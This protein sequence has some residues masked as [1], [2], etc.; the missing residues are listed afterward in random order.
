MK[1]AHTHASS[2]WAW[3]PVQRSPQHG[4]HSDHHSQ[5][6]G[7]PRPKQRIGMLQCNAASQFRVVA[8]QSHPPILAVPDLLYTLKSHLFGYPIFFIL[9]F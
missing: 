1:F 5:A 4:P 7:T 6:A 9:K 3:H 8:K 2:A